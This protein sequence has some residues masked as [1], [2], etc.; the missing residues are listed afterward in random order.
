V[1]FLFK[2]RVESVKAVGM[3]DLFGR[4]AGI[5]ASEN[6]GF[7]FPVFVKGDGYENIRPCIPGGRGQ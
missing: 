5:S 2:G 4:Y 7:R 3:V 6:R 1:G